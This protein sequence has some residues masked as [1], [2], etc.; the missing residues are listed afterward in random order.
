MTPPVCPP[1][2]QD[3]K[4]EL[5]DHMKRP[6]TSRLVTPGAADALNRDELGF[7]RDL[8]GPANTV[9]PG[10]RERKPRPSG[11]KAFITIAGNAV[12]DYWT[13]DSKKAAQAD[14]AKKAGTGENYLQW[15][16]SGGDASSSSGDASGD[17]EP[18]LR[19]KSESGR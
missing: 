13:R 18:K 3:K 1:C 14:A 15:S 6:L 19:A 16:S 12:I 8:P 7:L 9:R 5:F 4:E 11:K 17:D 10:R 2:A